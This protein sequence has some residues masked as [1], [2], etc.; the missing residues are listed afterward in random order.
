MAWHEPL[1]KVWEMG[2]FELGE[3]LAALPDAD[4]WTRPH[5]KLLSV[6]EI[7]AHLVYWEANDFPKASDA[8]LLVTEAARYYTS[9]IEAP[10]VLDIGG[11]QLHSEANRNFEACKAAFLATPRSE[12]EPNPSRK[13][14]TWRQTL[15]YKSFHVAY[16]TGQV[17]S[18]RHLLGHETV[19][20]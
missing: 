16:H 2:Y 3:A 12:D 13:E 5:P 14:W 6:G 17:Y 4:V 8:S 11:Q 18:V 20:N 10:L 15:E 19:D 9:N 1:V 7:V